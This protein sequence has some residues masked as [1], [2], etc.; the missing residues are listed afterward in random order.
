M[1]ERRKGNHHLSPAVYLLPHPQTSFPPKTF[2]N[3]KLI[4]VADWCVTVGLTLFPT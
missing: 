4:I 3:M 2:L 1:L